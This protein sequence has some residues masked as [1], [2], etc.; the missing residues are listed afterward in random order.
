MPACSRIRAT[1]IPWYPYWAKTRAVARTMFWRA[2]ACSSSVCGGRPGLRGFAA[3][4]TVIDTIDPLT[5][6][7]R[8]SELEFTGIAGPGLEAARLPDA[9]NKN[10]IQSPDGSRNWLADQPARSAQRQMRRTT[11]LVTTSGDTLEAATMALACSPTRRCVR[12]ARRAVAAAWISA[13]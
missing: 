13:A 4:L 5:G 2:R 10:T 9:Q 1:L 6:P 12:T 7:R 8:F 3:L 11:A